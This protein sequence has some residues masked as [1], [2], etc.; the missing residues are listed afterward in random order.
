MDNKQH[1][2]DNSIIKYIIIFA[3]ILFGGIIIFNAVNSP[4]IGGSNII[5][6]NNS[7][8]SIVAE[9]SSEQALSSVAS[10]HDD[11][12]DTSSSDSIDTSSNNNAYETTASQ[13]SDIETYTLTD[14]ININT[15][16]A[17]ELMKLPN[18]GEITADRIIEYRE[19]NGNYK[20]IEELL[21]VY[22]I[23]ENTFSKI[24]DYITV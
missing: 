20:S 1:D 14:K 7:A 5:Y 8:Y 24:K 3:L 15:A 17:N 9:N 6:V 19:L 4:L 18:I 12:G 16:T 23:G 11:Y 13:D 10:L 22:G 2:N 21:N